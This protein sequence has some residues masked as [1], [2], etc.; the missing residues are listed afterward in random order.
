M[1]EQASFEPRAVLAPRRAGW[2]RLAVLVPAIG[3]VGAV[4]FGTSGPQSDSPT[5]SGDDKRVAHESQAEVAIEQVPQRA[6]EA[7]P[8]T[9]LGIEVRTLA[10]LDQVGVH[11]RPVIAVA[12]WYVAWPS[13]GCPTSSGVDQPGLVAELGVDADIRTFCDRSGVLVPTPNPA[14]STNVGGA[15]DHPYGSGAAPALPVFLTP[16]AVVPPEVAAP[17]AAPTEVILVGRLEEPGQRTFQATT[18]RRLVVDRVVW[19]DGIGRAQTTSI[20][21]KLLDQGPQLASRPRDRL[22][23]AMIGPTGAILMETL[24]DPA[25]LAFVDPGAAALVADTSPTSQR[26]WYRLALG[27]HPDRIAPRWIT[28]DDATGAVIGT[29]ILGNPSVFV[30]TGAEDGEGSQLGPRLPADGTNVLAGG[31]S[32]GA[33]GAR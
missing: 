16:G 27:I 25:T 22:A 6:P 30:V 2:S 5:P 17:D 23:E 33:A 18:A 1:D 4:W 29:G 21:P 24:V 31:S 28:I 15:N 3:L 19:A 13:L 8:T 26:I 20:L 12:G 9:V 14:G 10:D 32:S 7:Y 11:D